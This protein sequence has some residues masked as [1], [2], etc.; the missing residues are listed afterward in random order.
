MAVIIYLLQT[1]ITSLKLPE[2][3]PQTQND[4]WVGACNKPTF[5]N[6]FVK[7]SDLTIMGLE[8]FTFPFSHFNHI[9][10]VSFPLFSN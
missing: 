10:C 7:A 3:E 9:Q 4:G 2:W 1:D 5:F 6:R 8:L